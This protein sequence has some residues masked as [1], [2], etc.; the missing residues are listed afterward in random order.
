M[1]NSSAVIAFIV[2]V[3]ALAAL[4]TLATV[5]LRP[6]VVRPPQGQ[7]PGPSRATGPWDGRSFPMHPDMNQVARDMG[8]AVY[9]GATGGGGAWGGSS[10]GIGSSRRAHFTG[11]VSFTTSATYD[12]VVRFYLNQY[13]DRNPE[14]RRSEGP[15]PSK[16]LI[17]WEDSDAGYAV[18][19][20]PSGLPM[21]PATRFMLSRTQLPMARASVTMPQKLTKQGVAPEQLG[22]PVYAGAKVDY[23]GRVQGEEG[24]IA[25]ARLEVTASSP[26]IVEF[27]QDLTQAHH[28][29]TR[30]RSASNS[31]TVEL[32]TGWDEDGDHV[33]VVILHPSGSLPAL[34]WL[35]RGRIVVP[36][37]QRLHASHQSVGGKSAR[38]PTH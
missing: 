4:M 16:A 37:W 15:P 35:Q 18:L 38:P 13:K 27:Y 34:I 19:V 3:C 2:A 26:Q 7:P 32:Q 30:R 6:R 8:I 36:D 9:P 1:R 20:Q 24:E 22:L 33:G 12:Q 23:S 29:S 31:Q 5:V 10:S 21:M 25:M 11:H 28:G 14:I 17:F